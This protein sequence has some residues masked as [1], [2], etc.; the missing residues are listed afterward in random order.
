MIFIFAIQHLFI[1]KKFYTLYL[2]LFVLF[3]DFIM[4]AQPGEDGEG[5]GLEGN[6]PP[7][8]PINGKLLW[9]AILGI[10]FSF[11]YFNSKKQKA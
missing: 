8:A 9:L 6:D 1:M 3:S 11:Y 7:A 5:G 10:L 4:F 2:F